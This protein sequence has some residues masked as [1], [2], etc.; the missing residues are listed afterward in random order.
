MLVEEARW[1]LTAPSWSPRGKS[2]AFGRFVPQSMEPTQSGQRGRFEVVIQDAMNRK[3]VFWASRNSSSMTRLARA[4][5]SSRSPGA[6]TDDFWRSLSP[7]ASPR[8]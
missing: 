4:F 3:R 6:L 1:P 2:I 7:V 5:P 8:S